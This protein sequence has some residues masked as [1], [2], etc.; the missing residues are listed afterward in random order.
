MRKDILTEPLLERVYQISHRI[1]RLNEKY[2]EKFFHRIKRL[3]KIEISAL[4]LLCN[5]P[6]MIMRDISEQLQV[7]K[8]TM[9]GVVDKLEELGF[10]QRVI[11]KND[12]RSYAL[13]VTEEGKLAQEEHLKSE[14]E[15]YL[16]IIEAMRACDV[17]DNYLDQ[18][19]KILEYFESHSV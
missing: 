8:S 16:H 13:E 5:N 19:E 17:P 15:A 9:T 12:R 14:R 6:Q 11:N 4:S 10:L 18:T 1:V 2:D 7:S 3:S